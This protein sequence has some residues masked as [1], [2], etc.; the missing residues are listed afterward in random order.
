MP[1]F[2]L[3]SVFQK[4]EKWKSKKNITEFLFLYSQCVSSDIN[5]D[6]YVILKSVL[7]FLDTILLKMYFE[8]ILYQLFEQFAYKERDIERDQEFEMVLKSL[9]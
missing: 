6:M 1:L 8:F 9:K 4:T 3:Y 2:S 7:N 5:I